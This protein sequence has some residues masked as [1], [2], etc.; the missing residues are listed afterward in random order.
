MTNKMKRIRL[1]GNQIYK[2]KNLRCAGCG[3]IIMKKGEPMTPI[4]Y[5][6][7]SFNLCPKCNEETK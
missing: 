5:E 3:F 7:K 4:Y 1:G 2:I 6:G